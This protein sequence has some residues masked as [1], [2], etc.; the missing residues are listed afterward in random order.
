[1]RLYLQR[2]KFKPI[3]PKDKRKKAAEEDAVVKTEPED[4]GAFKDLMRAV[5]CFPPVHRG[6][7]RDG[8][9]GG[10][11]RLKLPIST[12]KLQLSRAVLRLYFEALWG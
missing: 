6:L 12:H 2:G 10:R 1:M 9:R 4:D 3:V 8:G 7:W 11:R 5:S